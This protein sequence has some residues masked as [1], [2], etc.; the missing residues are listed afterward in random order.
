ML[1]LKAVDVAIGVAFLYLLLTFSASAFVELVSMTLNWRAQMLHD[2]VENMLENSF[3][4][5]LD[6]IYCNAQVVALYRNDAARSW[7]DLFEP[8]GWGRGKRGTPPSYIPATIFSGAVL[9]GLMNKALSQHV[10]DTLDLSPLG[11]VT[12]IQKL[13]NAEI[14]AGCRCAERSVKEDA[15][16]SILTTTL[17]T[18]GQSIQAVRYAIEKWFND[19]M[20]RTS[21]WY[22][23]RSQACLLM[24]G[25]ALA[26]G[27]NLNTIAVAR[28]LWQGDAA[29]QAAITAASKY[30]NSNPPASQKADT[31]NSNWL[32]T[33]PEGTSAARIV[34]VDQ[35][36]SALHYPI[37]WYSVSRV[38][39]SI[40]WI[41]SYVAGALIT[42]L[43]I[44]MGSTFWF[45]AVQSLLNLR[46]TGP[47][48][49]SR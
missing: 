28:W 41:L 40:Y 14:T 44:S 49:N 10:V 15:L 1:P 45:D 8:H 35:Q 9:E 23:R 6:N 47:K 38:G 31:K 4:V 33:I 18:Q 25:L 39:T 19:T 17:A 26:F 2:A 34:D 30:V 11:T 7:V 42:G 5:T 13:L 43:A 27:A 3:L 46:G 16:R 29:R 22:K 36:L 12:L 32:Q 37:G 21:G 20:D 24:I 48:P